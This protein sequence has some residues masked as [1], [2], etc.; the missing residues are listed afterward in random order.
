MLK[1]ILATTLVGLTLSAVAAERLF[2]FSQFALNQSPTGF[3][4]TVSGQGQPGVWK[5]IEDDVPPLLAPLSP[6]APKVG[7]R[8]VLAQIAQETTDEHFPLLIFN[9]ESF[10]EFTLTTR[11]KIV[12][13]AIE[14]MAGVAFRIQDEKNYYVIRASSMGNTLRFYKF[15]G[16]LRSAPIGPEVPIQKGVWYEL[17]VDCKGNQI[18]FALNGKELI[19]PLTDNS[20]SAGKIGFWTKSDSVSYFVDTKMDYVPRVPFAQVLVRDM[21]EQYP[22]LLGLKIYAGK[23]SETPR[24]IA[25]MD[26]KDLVKCG[27]KVEADVIKQ[28]SIYYNKGKSSVE[29]TVPLRDRNGD[30]AAA[31]R[32]TMKSFPGETQ[33]TAL[34]R[35]L[36]IKKAM[37]ARIQA[38]EDLMQ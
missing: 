37:E 27:G 36:P 1:V 2:D 10:A 9:D 24:V 34:A 7:K 22:R 17:R 18:R 20:F 15:V 33:S 23:D 31:L 26:E 16:G 21:I 30:I 14:Q 29:V 12:S 6:N 28:G 32:T 11:F 38:V 4:S 8:A 35:I 25:S 19:P 3:V 5:I 13:G